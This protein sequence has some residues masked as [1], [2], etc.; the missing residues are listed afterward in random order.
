MMVEAI[1]MT[2]R[3][4]AIEKSSVSSGAKREVAKQS[5]LKKT[6]CVTEVSF[7]V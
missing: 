6:A 4:R 7:Y 1:G 5:F 3:L 2:K